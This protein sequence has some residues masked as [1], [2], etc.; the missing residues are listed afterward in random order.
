MSKK[1]P[2]V[3]GESTEVSDELYMAHHVHTLAHLVAHHLAGGWGATRA[4]AVPSAEPVAQPMAAPMPG[5]P[6]A[7]A[8]HGLGATAP[9]TGPMFVA[10]PPQSLVYWYP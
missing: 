6:W 4:F 7:P 3:G 8:W 5:M 10:V 2:R 9:A 1:I